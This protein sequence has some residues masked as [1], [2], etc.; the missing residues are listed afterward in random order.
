MTQEKDVILQVRNVG[1][2]FGGIVA[3][4]DVSFDIERGS[5]VGLIGP[6]GAGK[7]T[8]FDA[9]CG[10]VPL[11][12]GRVALAGK[13]ITNLAPAERS[14]VGLG[15]SFQD[16]KLFASLTVAETLACAL[17]RR[18]KMQDAVSTVLGLPWV[19]S[20]ER[21]VTRHVE[22]LIDL[23]GLGAFRDKFISELSTGSR[24]IVDLGC[25]LAHQPTV[26]L[27]DEPSSGIAQRETEALGPLLRRVQEAT[28]CTMLLV[29]HDM[30]LVTSVSDELIA[31]ET[32]R[33]IARGTPREVTN[34]PAVVEAYLGTDE[35]IVARSGA[36]VTSRSRD[37]TRKTARKPSAKRKPARSS[38]A[39]PRAM[40]A[41]AK[42]RAS[43]KKPPSRRRRG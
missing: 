33:V 19:W 8:L 35:R 31:L 24:R 17:E 26:L 11:Q 14:R 4:D 21:I 12:T 18:V 22:Q 20:A 5:I 3:V 30:P 16:A 32:G 39:K 6:N 34:H 1:V 28:E 36:V 27:L 42:P 25:V 43:T 15:R 10:F 13:E 38:S 2:A 29:E 41:S 9:I 23:L 37:G 7:T 40:K